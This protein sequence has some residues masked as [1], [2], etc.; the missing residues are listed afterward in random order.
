MNIYCLYRVSTEYSLVCYEVHLTSDLYLSF[1]ED[2]SFEYSEHDAD[3][4]SIEVV[5]S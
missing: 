1:Y 4:L 3:N 2:G 5:L